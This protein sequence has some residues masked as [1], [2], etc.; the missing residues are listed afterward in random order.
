MS[1]QYSDHQF[2]GILTSATDRYAKMLDD[3]IV[4]SVGNIESVIITGAYNPFSSA[5]LGG[6]TTDEGQNE[7]NGL[8]FTS[9]P[10]PVVLQ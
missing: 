9:G 7:K 10:P 8:D 5:T 1:V 2:I 3:I 6:F 4:Q